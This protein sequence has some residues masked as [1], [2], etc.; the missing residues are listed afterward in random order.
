MIR[1]LTSPPYCLF[2]RDCFSQPYRLF[3]IHFILF[4]ALYQLRDQ[5]ERAESGSLEIS[6]LRICMTPLH[7]AINAIADS[8]PLETYYRDWRNFV[9]TQP[10]HVDDMLDNFWRKMVAPSRSDG[11]EIARALETLELASSST[12]EEVKHQYRRLAMKHHP[13]RGGDT[14]RLQDVNAAKL[15]LDRHF[16]ATTNK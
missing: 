15:V 5:L 11:P 12:H 1:A 16:Q 7:P 9:K 3:Q 2:E 4:H 8:D 13:D 14:D 6:P 10:A